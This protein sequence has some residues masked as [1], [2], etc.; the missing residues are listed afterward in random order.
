MGGVVIDMSC[1]VLDRKQQA[2]PRLYAVGELTGLAGIN[3]KASLE[4]TFL[5][6]CI[7]TGRIAA[8]S[9][10]VELKRIPKR[11]TESARI[12]EAS[13]EPSME[14]ED[15]DCIDCHNLV[16][17]SQKPKTGYWHFI[18]S[19]RV[20]QK[21][22]YQCGLCHAELEPYCEENHQIDPLARIEKCAICHGIKK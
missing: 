5:G 22:K 21:R 8:R 11:V 4:G 9:A 15:E 10:L 17:L 16:S 20:V 14:A 2:I 19:H 18:K 1:R 12:P 3:G 7:I 6:Q 13:K